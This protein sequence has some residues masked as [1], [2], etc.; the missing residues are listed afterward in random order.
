[1]DPSGSPLPAGGTSFLLPSLLNEPFSFATQPWWLQHHT[2]KYSA[3]YRNLS[4]GYMPTIRTA[5]ML[6]TFQTA[7]KIN[8]NYQGL[9]HRPRISMNEVPVVALRA[10]C[11]FVLVSA[12]KLL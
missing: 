9:Q 2:Q 8:N 12:A 3:I 4:C 6:P 10:S 11:S 5:H 1:M 7:E